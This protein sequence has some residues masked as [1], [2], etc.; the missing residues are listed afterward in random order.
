MSSMPPPPPPGPPPAGSPRG[1]ALGPAEAASAVQGPAIALIVTAVLGGIFALIGIA[2][3][4]L[5]MGMSGMQDFADELGPAGN[6][7]NM[8]GGAMGVFSS[9]LGLVVAGFI[10]WAALEMMKLRRW[11]VAVV[12]SVVAMV[13]CVSPCCFL[14]IPVGIW[15]LVVLMREEVKGAFTP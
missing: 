4:V 1:P 7:G 11:T 9:I 15:S 5:G 3:N 13:P 2:F 10:G 6:L 12:A 14:G 8:V